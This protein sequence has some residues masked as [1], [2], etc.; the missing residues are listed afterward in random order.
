[1]KGT[2]PTLAASFEIIPPDAQG[3]PHRHPAATIQYIVKGQGH[4][5]ADGLRLEW[6]TG[7]M[8]VLPGGSAHEEGNRGESE[9][10]ILFSISDF[11]LVNGMRIM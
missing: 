5:L 2:T 4:L 7:D 9:P 10:A 3:R 1:L 11:P 8:V 6:D